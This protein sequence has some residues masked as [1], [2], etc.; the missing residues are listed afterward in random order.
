MTAAAPRLKSLLPRSLFGRSL[1]ILLVPIVVLQL[2]VGTIFFQRHYQRVT[3][4]MTSSFAVGLQYVT[5]H[6]EGTDDSASV[7]GWLASIAPVLD[8][9]VTLVPGA[10]V[11]PEVRRGLFDLTG[12][13]I[14]DTLRSTLSAPFSID[15][16]SDSRS[17][18]IRIATSH[19][20]LATDV[21]RS[22]LSVS[23]PHQLLVLMI[24]AAILLATIAVLFLRNQVKPI[25]RLAEA[26]EAFGKGRSLAYRP[27]GAEEVRRAGTAFLSMRARIERQIEQRTQMLSGVS[28]D[29]R[30]PLTRMKLTLAL[31]E[32]DEETAD[33][34]EDVDQMERMLSEFL[35]FARGDTT[36]VSES[37]DAFAL[38]RG[39]AE[40][41]ERTGHALELVEQ[42]ESP[43]HHL[44]DL[45]PVA[46]SRA[47]LNLTSNAARYGSRARLT[48]RLTPRALIFAVEDDGPG[49]PAEM[50]SEAVQPFA[51]LDQARNQNAGGNVGLGLSIAM[52]VARSHGG[53]LALSESPDLHGLRAELRLPR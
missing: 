37:V 1:V 50:R 22:R 38:G 29:L 33:L 47:V 13:T 34:R 6:V 31:M 5:R 42:D 49:I 26:A 10:T 39:I 24:L 27:G 46:V 14:A 28:H 35:D 12:Q 7:H 43:G 51:R 48:V 17:A 11:K 18:Q 36:E 20:V 53:A 30:T 15:L 8:A 32:E 19:G 21:P 40:Q 23:N 2:V 16:A 4:Q 3:Q 52:D 9:T 45:R 41:A 44:V 25:R